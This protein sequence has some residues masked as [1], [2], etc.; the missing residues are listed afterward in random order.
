MNL[1]YILETALAG[2]VLGVAAWTILA[3]N[4]FAASVGYVSYGLLLALVW[5]QLAAI[6]V[7]LTEAA[8]GSGLTGLLLLIAAARLRGTESQAGA[9]HLRRRGNGQPQPEAGHE[10]ERIDR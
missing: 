3:R 5:V 10:V 9:G 8:I 1:A 7:A 6:D 4:A 2:L